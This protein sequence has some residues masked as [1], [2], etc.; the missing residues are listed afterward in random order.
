M[1]RAG[2]Q[3]GTMRRETVAAGATVKNAILVRARRE[4]LVRAAIQVFYEKGYHRSRI[5]DVADAAGVSHGLIY[6]YVKCKEDLLYLVCEDH[7]SG[8]ERIVNAAL[9]NATTPRQRLDALLRATIDVIFEYR[10]H[11][12]VMLRELHH[13]EPVKR[14]AFFNLAVEQRKLI[15][16]ILKDVARHENV[17]MGDPLVTANILVYLPKLIVSRGWDLKGKV[18]N[19]TIA[20]TLLQFMQ[21]GLGLKLPRPRARMRT[22]SRDVLGRR[23]D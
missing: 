3:N 18:D 8:Y 22:R 19:E 21:R 12:V 9:K 5:A 17:L 1:E 20:Q 7:F 23:S 16:G 15:E 11:F 10:K 6:N 2:N 4:A 13:V 14:R